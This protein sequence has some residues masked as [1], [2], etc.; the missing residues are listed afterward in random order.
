MKIKKNDTG[1]TIIEQILTQ[2]K[3]EKCHTN[4]NAGV[5]VDDYDLV[6][7]STDKDTIMGNKKQNEKEYSAKED[8][9]TIKKGAEEIVGGTCVC[10]GC[11]SVKRLFNNV[12]STFLDCA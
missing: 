3:L 6:D 2:S 9:S 11:T 10:V 4:N 8:S 7:G 1:A 5:D 12:I